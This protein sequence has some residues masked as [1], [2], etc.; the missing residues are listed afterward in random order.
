MGEPVGHLDVKAARQQIDICLEAG[1][2]M[3]DTADIYSEG[4]S[5]KIAG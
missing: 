4:L 5:E 3:I 1:V 2:N